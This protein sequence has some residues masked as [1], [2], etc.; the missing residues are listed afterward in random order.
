MI[1]IPHHFLTE[2]SI[3]LEKYAHILINCSYV[4]TFEYN[5]FFKFDKK[6]VKELI[7]SYNLHIVDAT[8]LIYP[9]QSFEKDWFK[10]LNYYINFILMCESQ[11]L[12]TNDESNPIYAEKIE[13]NGITKANIFFNLTDYKLKISFE[14]NL[15]SLRNAS[16]LLDFLENDK[17]DKD[18]KIITIE[19][20]RQVGGNSIF[21]YDY[22]SEG[23]EITPMKANV[24]IPQIIKTETVITMTDVFD[25]KI[26]NIISKYCGLE[27]EDWEE[28]INDGI[29]V[30]RYTIT[31]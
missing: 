2:L 15:N 14:D 16:P 18:N 3:F 20:K 4:K 23:D 29:W 19:G 8:G 24:T 11:Y 22:I 7:A 31:K 6:D 1:F 21:R 12:C 27:I 28:F 13:V 25:E 5:K 26:C 9:T 30:P 17:I 10:S